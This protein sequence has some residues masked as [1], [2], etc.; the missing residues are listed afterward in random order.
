MAFIEMV[1]CDMCGVRDDVLEGGD[2]PLG[3]CFSDDHEGELCPK[4][5]PAPEDF[6]DLV[7]RDVCE[8]CG[9]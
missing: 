2:M 9:R 6:E 1:V 4:C 7:G 3:W 8:C 5:C